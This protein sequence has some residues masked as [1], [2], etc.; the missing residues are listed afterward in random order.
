MNTA[1]NVHRLSQL[2]KNLSL[3]PTSVHT[4]QCQY[5]VH[6]IKRL[7]WGSRLITLQPVFETV[8]RRDAGIAVHSGDR[9][10]ATHLRHHRTSAVEKRR[11][12]ATN[13][14]SGCPAQ[15]IAPTGCRCNLLRTG[16]T[17]TIAQTSADDGDDQSGQLAPGV[18]ASPYDDDSST[19]RSA[20]VFVCVPT[21]PVDGA[22]TCVDTLRP[23]VLVRC[24]SADRLTG[25]GPGALSLAAVVVTVAA[26]TVDSGPFS[27]VRRLPE[28]TAR[29]TG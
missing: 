3:P 26:R 24:G 15:L 13:A 4:A 21:D 9:Q 7:W 27:S 10:E 11:G 2:T 6:L 17:C 18:M 5:S 29:S 16:I 20:D 19:S 1:H 25:C 28:R 8:D 14:P 12:P 23:R 22:I